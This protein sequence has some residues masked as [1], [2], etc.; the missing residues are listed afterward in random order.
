MLDICYDAPQ[1]EGWVARKA[2]APHVTWFK[3]RDQLSPL[4]IGL[5]GNLIRNMRGTAP[6]LHGEEGEGLFEV[7]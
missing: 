3:P 1:R 5:L 7:T 4:A 6:Q 2:E